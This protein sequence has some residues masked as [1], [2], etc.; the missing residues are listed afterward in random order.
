MGLIP[1]TNCDVAELPPQGCDFLFQTGEAILLAALIGL[2]PYLP[3]PDGP[4][5]EE[6][7]TYVSMGPP[8]AEF[9]DA[10]SIYLVSYDQTAESKARMARVTDNPRHVLPVFIATW[11]MSL[12]ENSYPAAEKTPDGELISYPSPQQLHAVNASVYAHGIAAYDAL[13]VSIYAGS[14]TIREDM[15]RQIEKIT[16]GGMRPLGPQGTAVGWGWDV[17]TEVTF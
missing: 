13:A 4:C 8:V 7:A 2:G 10:L 3:D 16:V 12:W 6:F 17:T 15:P 1:N 11:R 14:Q 9:Y 5:A